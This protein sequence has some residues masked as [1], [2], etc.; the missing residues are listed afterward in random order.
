MNNDTRQ[1][2][3]E[4]LMQVRIAAASGVLSEETNPEMAVVAVMSEF[5][6]Q[7]YVGSLLQLHKRLGEEEKQLWK[8]AFTKMY[9]LLGNPKRVMQ[10]SPNV[11]LYQEA[12]VGITSLLT[13]AYVKGLRSMC[14]MFKDENINKNGY[15]YFGH[16]RKYAVDLADDCSTVEQLLVDVSHIINESLID[17]KMNAL[18]S[19]N[20]Q[21]RNY[22][23][24]PFKKDKALYTRV[25][26][27]SASGA[28]KVSGQ[29]Y[30]V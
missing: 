2:Q 22:E 5:N 16:W 1:K 9:F 30:E 20:V 11:F 26:F 21:F 19:I 24:R 14:P 3:L 13:P 6:F 7:T 10:K 27:D 18:S 29:L 28:Y 17:R 8:A 12:N 4:N 25:L 15:M 23:K